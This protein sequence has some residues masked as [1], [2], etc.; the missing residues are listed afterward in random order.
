MSIVDSEKEICINIEVR[1]KQERV[2]SDSERLLISYAQQLI[3]KDKGS[4]DLQQKIADWT[5]KCGEDK[6]DHT[7]IT[8]QNICIVEYM[9]PLVIKEN[10]PNVLSEIER[11]NN[12][13][14][15][16]WEK[17]KRIIAQESQWEQSVA[18]YLHNVS[19]EHP[20]IAR[21]IAAILSGILIGTLTDCVVDRAERGRREECY[22]KAIEEVEE[23]FHL[24]KGG[25][26]IFRKGKDG[27]KVIIKNN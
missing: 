19:E 27:Y 9:V 3:G 16:C 12:L 10:D 22:Q 4:L 2:Y 8:G 13:F 5:R 18:G 24:E 1:K 20:L 23:I 26:I 6:P 11:E 15:L 25:E 7:I 21:F 17:V 14:L